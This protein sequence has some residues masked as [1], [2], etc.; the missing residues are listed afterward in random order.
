MVEKSTL[1][2]Q[3]AGFS[4]IIFID[5]ANASEILKMSVGGRGTTVSIIFT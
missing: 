3:N 4:P 5:R 1:L 2:L